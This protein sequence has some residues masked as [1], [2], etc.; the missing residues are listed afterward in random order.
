MTP[1]QN[2]VIERVKQC[3]SLANQ[4]LN[5]RLTTPEVRFNQRGK[6]AGS[7]RLQGWEVRFNP[8]LLEENPGAFL[9]EVVP[10]EV[11]HLVVFKLFGKVRPHGREW[12]VIM[13]EVFAVTPRTTHSFDVSSVQGQTFHYRCQCSDHQMTVRRHNK[14]RRGQAHYRC[15]Q[16]GHTL[17]LQQQG[18]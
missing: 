16:C 4:R 14:I 9:N 7:A 5:K 13:Q 15:R 10:H 3:I 18:Q 2:Q 12:Q 17:A 6:I 1:L 11:A 8:V